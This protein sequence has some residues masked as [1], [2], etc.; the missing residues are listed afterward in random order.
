[1]IWV[2]KVGERLKSPSFRISRLLQLLSKH[3]GIAQGEIVNYLIESGK[4][5]MRTVLKDLKAI[6]EVERAIREKE[7]KNAGKAIEMNLGGA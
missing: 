2:V 7:R 5:N 3:T 4:K 1:M 6:G